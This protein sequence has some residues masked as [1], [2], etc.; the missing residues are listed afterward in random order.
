[1]S[2]LELSLA[3]AA[4]VIGLTGAWSPCGFSM[5]ETVGQAGHGARRW[6]TIAACAAFAP[7]AVL[8]GVATFGL[9]SVIG[10]EAHGAGGRVRR[11]VDCCAYNSRRINGD[12]ALTGYCF[13]GRKVFCVMYFQT[14][15]PC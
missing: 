10:Q 8:G 7:G 9:L 6:T 12:A 11:L 5:V 4:L 13:E 15:V 2:A 3:G 14:H 1:M